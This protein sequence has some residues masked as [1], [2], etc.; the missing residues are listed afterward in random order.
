MSIRVWQNSSQRIGDGIVDMRMKKEDVVLEVPY[1]VSTFVR[2]QRLSEV[3]KTFTLMQHMK[4]ASA[5]GQSLARFHFLEKRLLTS[6]IPHST[7][8]HESTGT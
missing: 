5:M 3:I 4:I 7:Q 1:L 2:G 6:H 8:L